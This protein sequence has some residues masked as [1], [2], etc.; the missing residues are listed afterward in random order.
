MP[1]VGKELLFVFG[2]RLYHQIDGVA[3]G[4]PLSL[5]L[6]NAFLCHYEKNWLN[7]CSTEFKSEL[8]KRFVDDIFVKFWSR[9]HVKNFVDYKNTK[10]PNIRL[11]FEQEDQNNFSSLDMKIIRN[12]LLKHQF[13]EGVHSVVFLL[14]SRVL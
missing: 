8:Y 13:I 10:H 9:Y 5:T 3:I 4:L 11:T 12:K 6:T 2:N 1:A 7:S 14:I